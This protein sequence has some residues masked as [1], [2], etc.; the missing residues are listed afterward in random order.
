[1]TQ[2]VTDPRLA[3]IGLTAMDNGFKANSAIQ[4]MKETTPFSEYRQ[5]AAVDN[6]GESSVFTGSKALGVHGEFQSDN[7][8]SIGNLLS[9]PN[10]PK[11]MGKK[12]IETEG[13]QITDRL[14]AAIEK[15]FNMGG[16]L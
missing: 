3:N 16:E 9:D 4:A 14:I 2:N 5:L 6:N 1:L 10:I 13:L 7:V 15:G 8:A 11:E 12:F